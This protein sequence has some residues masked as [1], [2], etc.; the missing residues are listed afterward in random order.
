[1][2]NAKL[3]RAADL[4]AVNRLS[5]RLRGAEDA[6]RRRELRQK[7]NQRRRHAALDGARIRSLKKRIS[8]VERQ[9]A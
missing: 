2:R 9:L 8:A 1:L 4:R 7:L 6:G 3:H 5:T